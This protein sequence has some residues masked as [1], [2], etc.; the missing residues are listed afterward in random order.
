ML[1][2]SGTY[3]EVKQAMVYNQHDAMV[4]IDI[5]HAIEPVKVTAGHPF[6]ALRGIPMGQTVERSYAQLAN[7]KV[8]PAWVEANQLQKGD[9]VAQVI[10]TEIVL[11][12][13]FTAEDARFIMVLLGDGHMSKDGYEWGVSGNPQSDSHLSFVQD[14]LAARGIHYWE[15]VRGDTYRQIH[16]ASGQGAVRDG[17]TGRIVG[18]GATTLPFTYGDLYNAQG[19]KRIARKFSHLPHS[20]TL[21]LIQGLLE[22]DGGVSRGKEI[23]PVHRVN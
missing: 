9:Y 23:P 19:E 15:T 22:T 12:E 18:A 5:K 16:W 14:Y 4:A 13:G 6:Y 1:G 7:A 10:P 2:I 11:V 8:R 3:R 21:S 20:Q 17:T